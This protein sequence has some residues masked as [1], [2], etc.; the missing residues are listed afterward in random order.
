M[1]KFK[2]SAM[3]IFMALLVFSACGGGG[4]GGSDNPGDNPTNPGDDPVLTYT[5]PGG[6][7]FKMI[8]TPD[9]GTGKKCNID[10]DNIY[11]EETDVADVPARFIMGE[12]EVTYQLWKEVYDWATSADRGADKYTFA[13][14]GCEGN[15]GIEGAAPT[16]TSKQKPVTIVNWRDTIVWCNALTE[17][18]NAYNDEADLVCVYSYNGSIIRDSRDSNATACDGAVQNPSAK[19]FR[20]P[21][22]IEWEFAG[23]YISATQPVHANYVEKDGIYYTKGNS[24]SGATA[25]NTDASATSA[26]AVYDVSSTAVVKSKGASGANSL[27]LYDMTGNVDEWCFDVYGS[28]SRVIR[29]GAYFLSASFI[30]VGCVYYG[31]PSFGLYYIGFRFCK[32]K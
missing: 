18:Y 23:R 17:Y 15:D 20:L 11:E 12:T 9:V 25:E 26:V 13:H 8:T 29:S 19:G 32:N 22:N 6:T 21:G 7:V 10:E 16:E 2:L 24:A 31:P 4:G 5:L 1:K 3:M 27:G 30:R 14:A 28:S